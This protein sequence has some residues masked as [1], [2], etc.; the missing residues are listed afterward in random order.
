MAIS[1]TIE[2]SRIRFRIDISQFLQS[3][4]GE[5]PSAG[6]AARN[7]WPVLESRADR[8][9]EVLASFVRLRVEVETIDEPQRRPEDGE[10]EAQLDSGVLPHVT[11]AHRLLLRVDVADIHEDREVHR[12]RR[13]DDVFGVE[14]QHLVPADAEGRAMVLQ[15]VVQ[16]GGRVRA[17]GGIEIDIG[18]EEGADVSRRRH[19]PR[20]EQAQRPLAAEEESLIRGEGV[21]AEGLDVPAAGVERPVRPMP[22]LQVSRQLDRRPDEVVVAAE[23]S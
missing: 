8:E 19:G 16:A 11:Q 7:P 12:T 22:R 3:W 9:D 6:A 13:W 23:R 20:L 4:P 5:A 14:E 21:P 1:P 2:S 10:E 15:L 18:R 17:V